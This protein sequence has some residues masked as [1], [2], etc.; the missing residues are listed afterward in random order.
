MV[1]Q[2]GTEDAGIVT[3]NTKKNVTKNAK[4]IDEITIRKRKDKRFTHIYKKKV[5]PKT[6]KME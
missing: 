5:A 3:K 1:I 4:K 6:R 2:T